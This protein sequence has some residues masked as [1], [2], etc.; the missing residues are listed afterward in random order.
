MPVPTLI[1]HITERRLLLILDSCEH[2]LTGCREVTERLLKA[3]P[4]LLVLATSRQPLGIM[5]EV[6]LPVPALSLPDPGQPDSP[7]RLL[8]SESGALFAERAAA[9]TPEFT[10]T[11]E[12]SGTVAEL[13]RRLEGIPLAIELATSWLD[14]FTAEQLLE[15]LDDH[16][17]SMASVTSDPRHRTL[18]AAIGWSHALLTES[19]QVLWRRLSVFAGG[20][21]L[22]SAEAVCVGNG[23]APESLLGLLGSL[24]VKSIVVRDQSGRRP[25]YRLLDLIRRFGLAQLRAAGEETALRE[26]HSEAVLSLAE[27]ASTQQ[28]GPEQSAWLDRL[29][30]EHANIRAALEH[31]L[32]AAGRTDRGLAICASLFLFW[33]TRAVGEGRRWLD[34]LLQ[35]DTG[36]VPARARALA[37]S[38]A[39]AITQN[40]S[41]AGRRLLEK[42]LALGRQLENTKWC[43]F[44]CAT[45][46]Q[47]GVRRRTPGSA[48]IRRTW[49]EAGAQGRIPGRDGAPVHGR[50]RD[51]R[52]G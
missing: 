4:G 43:S 50:R 21:D 52:R 38:G 27:Q 18:Q 19:E 17:L 7:S 2:L 29:E 42:G 12:N 40:D 5:G 9:T 48:G 15:R 14:A 8:H 11:A 35:A 16:L 30:L 47:R 28:W 31:C 41:R 23:L 3:C 26:R 1:E 37:V 46:D 6:R 45:Y 33:S 34:L 44:H 39:L 32:A 20:F 10:I 51:C 24:V 22:V 36:A 49:P 13:C 25:R